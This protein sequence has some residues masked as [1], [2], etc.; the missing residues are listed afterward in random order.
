MKSERQKAKA[1]TLDSTIITETANGPQRINFHNTRKDTAAVNAE[2][3]NAMGVSKAILNNVIFCH[4]EDSTWPL[5]GGQKLKKRFDEIFDTVKYDK[6]IDKFIKSRKEYEVKHK[7]SS[8]NKVILLGTKTDAEQ[9]VLHCNELK[10][11]HSAMEQQVV[12]IEQLLVPI[13]EQLNILSVQE[14][15][16]NKYLE[17]KC[18]VEAK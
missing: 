16:F 14:Q 5:S 3:T 2:M 13:D 1:S 12:A 11:K 4:Q 17:R 8:N 15:E 9:K 6:A 10:T 7:I 18:V